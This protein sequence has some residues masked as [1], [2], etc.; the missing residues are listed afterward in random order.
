[1]KTGSGKFN[2]DNL[3]V[4]PVIVESHRKKSST[5]A[6]FLLLYEGRPTASYSFKRFPVNIGRTPHNDLIFNDISLHRHHAILIFN[7]GKFHII[8]VNGQK[9]IYH[10]GKAVNQS[11]IQ[12]GDQIQLGRFCFLFS[13]FYPHTTQKQYNSWQTSNKNRKIQQCCFARLLMYDNGIRQKTY[14]LRSSC[15]S[16]GRS[17]V[18]DIN[19]CEYGISRR[20][21]SIERFKGQY[22]IT[23][24]KSVTGTYLNGEVIS[25]KK[26][27]VSGDRIQIGMTQFLFRIP[28][29]IFP[30]DWKQ[31]PPSVSQDQHK[32]FETVSQLM[33]VNDSETGRKFPIYKDK[34]TIGRSIACDF[35][36]NFP[37]IS[38]FHASLERK[39]Q[40]LFISDLQS[41]NGIRVNGKKVLV[42]I[43]SNGDIIYIGGV[44]C[45]YLEGNR[46]VKT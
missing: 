23:D 11:L 29:K 10:N 28:S 34:I 43:L 35:Q 20:H 13:S 2:A 14:Y 40:F 26:H 7:Q 15:T 37:K 9:S 31:S 27:L 22:I 1:M 5:Q 44:K 21:A 25:Q 45:K 12:T 18:N 3:K 4:Y 38:R 17:E 32:Q 41:T 24:L 19:I 16:I 42:H 30:L 33:I 39:G 36:L 46:E 6:S 8:A